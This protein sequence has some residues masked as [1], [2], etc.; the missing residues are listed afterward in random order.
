[1]SSNAECEIFT[2]IKD[3]MEHDLMIYINHLKDTSIKSVINRE[4]DTSEKNK[5]NVYK[6]IL[7]FKAGLDW[8]EYDTRQ[9]L[10]I[11]LTLIWKLA[12]KSMRG[13]YST[14]EGGLEGEA[15][16]ELEELEKEIEEEKIN[17]QEYI[18][19]CNIIRDLKDEK[20]ILLDACICS[21]LG[22]IN[23]GIKEN[24]DGTKT[25]IIVFRVMCLPCG[26]NGGSLV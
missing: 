5:K 24:A 11:E 2:Y 1:M 19:R 15:H 26:W 8:W 25:N 17:E 13:Y 4:L 22:K 10:A 12:V 21:L 14:R 7:K 6:R 3:R 18:Q 9:N 23:D 20:E 16:R